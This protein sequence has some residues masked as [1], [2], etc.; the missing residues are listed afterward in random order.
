[1]H[2]LIDVSF[3]TIGQFLHLYHKLDLQTYID[4]INASAPDSEDLEGAA[5]S[6]LRLQRTYEV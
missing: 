4:S 5:A 3:Q 1:M 2:V 6:L